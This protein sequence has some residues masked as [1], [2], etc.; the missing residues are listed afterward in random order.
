MNHDTQSTR[1]QAFILILLA[2]L[3]FSLAG[4]KAA[5]DTG[6]AD[7]SSTVKDS[8][9]NDNTVL[10]KKYS[11]QWFDF[12]IKTM[13]TATE[14]QGYESEPGYKFVVVEIRET[15][16]FSSSL[17]M[18][19]SDYQLEAAGLMEEEK[20]PYAPFEGVSTMMPEEFELTQ[21]QTVDYDLVY[22]IPEAIMDIS[23]VYVEIDLKG[24]VGATFTLDYSL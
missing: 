11:T 1:R 16:T 6:S 4:C 20:L 23:L 17:R 12:T 19:A 15:N 22:E 7:T 13:T 10:N 5:S 2:A 18:S 14:Y 24:N 21:G 9:N 8:V 3:V